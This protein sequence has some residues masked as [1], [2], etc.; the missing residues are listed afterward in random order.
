MKFKLDEN[1]GSR[2][3]PLFREAGHDADTVREEGLA[4]CSDHDL[5][6]ACRQHSR[7]LVTLDLDFAD[8][9]RFPPH[10]TAGIA[11]IRLPKNP[12]LPLLERLISELLK[13]V[14][15]ESFEG[16]LWIVEVG[17]IRVHDATAEGE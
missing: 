11:V 9:V 15:L 14:T 7:S 8:V 13:T 2:T 1:F 4:G 16:R 10:L 6:Q 3:L 12:S 17:R 5:F